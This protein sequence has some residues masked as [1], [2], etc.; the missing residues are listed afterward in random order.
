MPN[1]RTMD[2]MDEWT[3][4]DDGG[5]ATWWL[6]HPLQRPRKQT[7]TESHSPPDHR[8]QVLDIPRRKSHL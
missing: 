6:E 2:T 8:R 4:W 1:I 5:S 7:H 3:E